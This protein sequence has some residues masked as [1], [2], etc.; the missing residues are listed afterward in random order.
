MNI[1]YIANHL[2][3]GGITSYL[4]I[5][6]R[7]LKKRGHNI[8]LASSG[9][10]KLPQ[11]IEEGVNFVR[12]P[13]KTKQEL[14]PKIILSM[15]KLHGIIKKNNID[16]IHSHSRTTQVLG[17][18]LSRSTGAAH[19]FTCHGFFKRRAL[20]RIFPCWGKKVIAISEQVKEHL[21]NDFGVRKDDI[22]LI[23]NGIDV[24]SFKPVSGAKKEEAR[25]KLGLSK[26]A[27]IGIVARLSDVK[28]HVY[29]IEAFKKVL[30][31]TPDAQLLI[32]GEGKMKDELV[33]LIQRFGI[34]KSVYFIPEVEDT[35]DVLSAIDVFV[36]PS[37]KEG[38]G[39]ALMEAMACGLPV[40][41]S[42]IGGIRSLI[43]NRV[44]GLLV[45]AADAEGLS[46]AISEL[47]QNPEEAKSFG[48]EA[49]AVINENFSES[50]MA[51]ETERVYLNV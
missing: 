43:K 33:S 38:L 35:R 23:H 41:G 25:F 15:L 14:S 2:N 10:V 8:Y 45:K 13:I 44:N 40:V 17:C 42:D 16:V 36:M 49:R 37:L 32:A 27:L 21:I 46:K 3:T 22:V 12:I 28:G 9:G 47:L 31:K 7:G 29:L 51:L 19:I 24:N 4:L 50:R 26:G 30:E 6:A 5:L 20:R 34:N 11:F 48:V 18:L 39:L 1:L